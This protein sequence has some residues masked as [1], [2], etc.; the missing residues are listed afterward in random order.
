M[1]LVLVQV[2]HVLGNV[3]LRDGDLVQG[4]AELARVQHEK[5]DRTRHVGESLFEVVEREIVGLMRRKRILFPSKCWLIFYVYQLVHSE[6]VEQLLTDPRRLLVDG[7]HVQLG[8]FP[9]EGLVLLV[10]VLIDWNGKMV[11]YVNHKGVVR[12]P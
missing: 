12:N 10:L 9:R 4:L 3:E 11:W 6:R 1:N 2:G 5:L 7:M 8:D